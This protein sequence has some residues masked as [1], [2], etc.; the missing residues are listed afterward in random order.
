MRRAL[1]ALAVVGAAS[2]AGCGSNGSE[3]GSSDGAVLDGENGDGTIQDGAL[4]DG[5]V[6]A[7][8]GP[9]TDGPAEASPQGDAATA[10]A[11]SGTL[12]VT[13]DASLQMPVI[14]AACAAAN[15]LLAA[16]DEAVVGHAIGLTASGIDSSNQTSDVTLTW[17]AAGNAGSLAATT[18][19]SNTFNC[20]SVGTATVTVTAAI[21]SGGASCPGIGSLAATLQCDAP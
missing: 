7:L 20:T 9:S 4:E 18:G 10:D 1:V 11:N 14:G 17:V 21:S 15:M 6:G 12:V 3:E 13:A 8:D 2:I 19:R 5:P 16:P